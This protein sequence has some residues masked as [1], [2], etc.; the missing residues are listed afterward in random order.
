MKPSL[1]HVS[2]ATQTGADVQW[3]FLLSCVTQSSYSVW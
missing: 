2:R 3:W 1:L